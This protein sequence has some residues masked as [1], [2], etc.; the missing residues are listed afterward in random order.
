MSNCLICNNPLITTNSWGKL[1]TLAE[2]SLLCDECSSKLEKVEGDRCA[3][4]DRS[5]DNIATEY[6]HNDLCYDCV[7][8]QQDP[9]WKDTICKNR[10]VYI[11]NAY[12][13]DIISLYK[14]RGDHV[15]SQLF[16]QEFQRVFKKHFDKSYIIIPIPLSAERLYERGFNQAKVLAELLQL[17]IIEVLAR[18]HL[19]K[20]SKKSRTERMNT[21]NV[22]SITGS[23]DIPS[24]KILI[25]DDIYTT[26]STLRHAAEVLLH[27]G[28]ESVSSLTLAR[29][30]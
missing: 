30:E 12:L 22:F 1:F 7:R 2:P 25:I 18:T 15:I 8:W 29:G 26:G 5:F 28:A 4:C 23:S 6:R 19:E 10:S 16:K 17:P 27:A 20:Q 11:Y 9:R 21:E 24:R 14:F 13:K 3:I